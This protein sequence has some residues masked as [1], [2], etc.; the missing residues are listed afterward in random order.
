MSRAIW[1]LCLLLIANW[2]FQWKLAEWRVKEVQKASAHIERKLDEVSSELDTVLLH[3]I[4]DP[5]VLER[6]KSHIN[7]K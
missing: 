1:L 7:D 3:Y 6:V 5:R 4:E 2:I